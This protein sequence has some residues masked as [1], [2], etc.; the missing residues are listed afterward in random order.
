MTGEQVPV[1]AGSKPAA[2]DGR[3]VVGSRPRLTIHESVVRFARATPVGYS[4]DV[5]R[6]S[7]VDAE[8][9]AVLVTPRTRVSVLNTPHNPTGAVLDVRTLAR[10]A[11]V[12]LQPDGVGRD[13]LSPAPA[14]PETRSRS[15]SGPRS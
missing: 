1:T 8:E 9:I 12:A 13:L 14:R 2:R 10:I 11:E 4:V 7:P 15:G 3:R 6:K 5:G